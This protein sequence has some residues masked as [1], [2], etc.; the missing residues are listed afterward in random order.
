M[1]TKRTSLAEV[2]EK[3]PTSSLVPIPP[4]KWAGG[5]RQLVDELLKLFPENFN[6]YHE[7]FLG[8]GAVFFALSDK[9]RRYSYL[10]DINDHLI[11]MYRGIKRG[12]DEVADLLEGRKSTRQAYEAVRADNFSRGNIFERAADFIYCNKAGFNGLCRYNRKGQF[13]VP[14]GKRENV[15]YCD[16]TSLKA[17][18]SALRRVDLCT[19]DFRKLPFEVRRGDLVYCDPPYAPLS[20][21]SDFTE[22]YK[23]G[24]SAADQTALR[25]VARNW[26]KRGAHVVIS[27]STAPL[28]RELYKGKEW[29][30]HEVQA[31]R[32][33]NSKVERR[34]KIG[35]LIIR[36]KE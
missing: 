5:K 6:T 7:P 14:W 28:I 8:G 11:S 9:I 4:V 17:V 21:D 18:Q 29:E 13:N 25:D 19:G 35:E 12:A 1:S 20:E 23:G 30:I 36:Y 16:R 15:T 26:G 22:Y 10:S 33:I 27:N 34:G 31:R 3:A 32:A 2:V 24:F